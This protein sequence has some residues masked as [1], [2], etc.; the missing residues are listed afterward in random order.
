MYLTK[1][2]K[3]ALFAFRFYKITTCPLCSNQDHD[4]SCE[5]HS[6]QNRICLSY[7]ATMQV[8]TAIENRL[9]TNSTVFKMMGEDVTFSWQEMQISA[10]N[11]V[12]C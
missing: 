10:E 7:H 3:Y 11:E 4:G 1:Y 9:E 6:H 5:C 12:V 8:L 2:L